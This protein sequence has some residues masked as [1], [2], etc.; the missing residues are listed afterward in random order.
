MSSS[1]AAPKHLI[2]YRYNRQVSPPATFIHVSL[3]H[4]NGSEIFSDWPAQLDTAADI[5]VVPAS[6]VEQLH[7]VQIDAIPVCGFGGL[8]S[9]VPTFLVRLSLRAHESVTIEVV[10]SPEEP[11]VLLGRDFLN[12]YR[13]V[14]DGPKF[15]LEIN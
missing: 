8:L 3:Q 6:L 12:R 9:T 13:I 10:A 5:T 11:H 15:Y 2:C 1:T 4:P 7:L 14:L